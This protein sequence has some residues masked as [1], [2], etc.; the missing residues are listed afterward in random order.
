[1]YILDP[2][3]Y[4]LP[5]YKISPF[6]TDD[7]KRNLRLP[8]GNDVDDYFHKRH[9]GFSIRYTRNGREA[10]RLAL[11]QLDLK[12]NDRITILTTTQNRYIS[13]CVTG[14][15]EKFCG[16]NR[17]PDGSTR[18]IILIHEF[19]F[20]HPGTTRL[21]EKYPV[22][23]IEDCAYSFFSGD[24]EGL[25]GRTGDYV[26]YSFPKMFPIQEGGMLVSREPVN[27]G[28]R[29]SDSQ[30]LAYYRK[31]LGHYLLQEDSIRK[32]RRS[33]HAYLAGQLV[34]RGFSERMALSPTEVPG[35]FLFNAPGI[36]LDALKEHMSRHGIQCS[37]FYGEDAFFLPIH[38]ALAQEDIDYFLFAL[39]AFTAAKKP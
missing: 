11:T 18:A 17:Q 9:P 31:V 24:P 12:R 21:R 4:L 23:I 6:Q 25:T 15:V 36:D 2:D 35:A 10:I 20:V 16:W 19:G 39:D 37:V 33:N 38:Q 22:P 13:S 27:F 7:I 32:Q 34:R 8:A 14:E 29:D 5:D 26:I 1:M 30:A 3:R 28:D